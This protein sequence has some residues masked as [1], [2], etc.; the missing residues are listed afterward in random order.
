[1]IFRAVVRSAGAAT[2]VPSN[3]CVRLAGRRTLPTVDEEPDFDERVETR[4]MRW[5]PVVGWHAGR[6]RLTTCGVY[7]GGQR[8]STPFSGMPEDGLG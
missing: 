3:R 7:G 2:A 4:G 5:L 6:R 8:G 1:M